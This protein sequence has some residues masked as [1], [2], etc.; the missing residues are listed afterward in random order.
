[1]FI[2]GVG[3]FV[4]LKQQPATP[5]EDARV[6]LAGPLW[7]AAAALGFLGVGLAAGWPSWLAI[8]R[9]GAWINL[10]NMLPIWQLDGGRAFVAL[11]RR[12]RGLIAGALWAMA[13][14][15]G[16]GLIF[17]LAIV[18]TARAFTATQAPREGD[19]GVFWSYLVL[20]TLFTLLV[21]LVPVPIR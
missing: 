19:R 15:G 21:R 10:F 3:A 8:A 17:V 6:G 13:L 14:L 11:S 7:G 16:D 20:A 5:Q 18:A 4:R 9:V 1:M 12:Q 2:P